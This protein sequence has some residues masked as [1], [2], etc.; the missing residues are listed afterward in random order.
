MEDE[1]RATLVPLPRRSD[2]PRRPDLRPRALQRW[3]GLLPLASLGGTA[4]S[5][6]E[7]LAE[8]NQQDLRPRIRLATLELLRPTFGFALLRLRRRLSF[9]QFPLPETT[10]EIRAFAIALLEAAAEG[11]RLA[12]A[13]GIGAERRP[14]RPQ[15]ALAAQRALRA[16][17]GQIIEALR[18]YEPPPAGAWHRLHELYRLAAAEGLEHLRVEDD[19]LSSRSGCTVA[20]AYKQ[21]LLLSA[22]GPHAIRHQEL[23][24][25]Y[26][27]LKR[28]AY[29]A[30]LLPAGESHPP[31]HAFFVAAGS[32]R[33]C[34]RRPGGDGDAGYW[35]DCTP[36]TLRAGEEP[37]PGRWRRSRGRKRL[38]R[39]TLA[40]IAEAL[41]VQMRPRARRYATEAQLEVVTGVGRISRLLARHQGL[42]ADPG[43][44]AVEV[45]HQDS[46]WVFDDD[47][48][49]WRRLEADELDSPTSSVEGETETPRRVLQLVD[50]NARGYCARYPGPQPISLRVGDTIA[51]R[52]HR[53]GQ[54]HWRIGVV[55]WLSQQ[56]GGL[57]LGTRL[58]THQPEPVLARPLHAP[59]EE[60]ATPGLML[61]EGTGSTRTLL[62]PRFNLKQGSALLM[63]GMDGE[64]TIVLGEKLAE[65]SCWQQFSF[66]EL[67]GR[68]ES[69]PEAGR[70]RFRHVYATL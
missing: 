35:L 7:A 36:L 70:Q 50:G 27:G 14:T 3:V 63:T 49:G 59:P 43:P 47:M 29:R 9:Q 53:A 67:E 15:L 18:F 6:Y 24:E 69:A 44:V 4:G 37:S 30:R 10:R 45:R 16:G 21:I 46:E 38:P 48:G 57:C 54:G 28:P 61:R 26:Q 19:G 5:L 39:Q 13:D 65:T 1:T 42:S 8:V 60:R 55:R 23:D 51:V 11:Y 56:E 64:Q 25:I 66:A 40:R 41:P 32:D 20:Q 2:D 58:L 34:T 17:S 22:I 68:R 62:L 33:G 52:P 12:L 31:P